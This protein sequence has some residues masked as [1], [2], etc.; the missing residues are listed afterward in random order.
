MNENRYGALEDTLRAAKLN[1]SAALDLR[2]ATLIES[3]SPLPAAR[4]LSFLLKAA[5][6]PLAAAAVL[7][8]M[9]IWRTSGSVPRSADWA[10]LAQ[11]LDNSRSGQWVHWVVDA[12]GYRGEA[13][14]AF[15]PYRY[16]LKDDG[17]ALY[18]D[19]GTGKQ[20]Y[21]ST[22]SGRVTVDP[23]DKNVYDYT[24]GLPDFFGELMLRVSR[25]EKEGAVL[26]RQ[27]TVFNGVACEL[28]TIDPTEGSIGFRVYVDRAAR[29][30]IREEAW[31]GANVTPSH[32]IKPTDYQYS[33]AGPED[34]YALGVPRDA[35]VFEGNLKQLRALQD[36]IES[37]RRAFAPSYFAV[38]CRA[39]VDAA[40]NVVPVE[41]DVVRKKDSRYRLEQYKVPD[42]ASVPSPDDLAAL[43]AWIA[44]A[45]V[46]RVWVSDPRP[47]REEVALWKWNAS[48]VEVDRFGKRHP[49]GGT[50]VW[51]ILTVEGIT[52]GWHL[53]VSYNDSGSRIATGH[54]L[55]GPLVTVEADDPPARFRGETVA[56]PTKRT[57]CFNPGRDHAAEAYQSDELRETGPAQHYNALEIRKVEEYAQTPAGR[58]YAK[59]VRT[60]RAGAAG[61]RSLELA[62]VHLDTSRAIHDE[63]MDPASLDSIGEDAPP[64]AE[65]GY[66]FKKAVAEIDAAP[67]YPA[68]PEDVAG[69][70]LA[71]RS[72]K[73]FARVELLMP[74]SAAFDPSWPA[75]LRDK[76][77]EEWVCG[78]ATPQQGTKVYRL[79]RFAGVSV[80]YEITVPCAR[81][82]HFDKDGIYDWY[83]GLSNASST[84]GRYYVV[85]LSPVN[86][87]AV[88]RKD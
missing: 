82:R 17:S 55:F 23:L 16:A 83:I 4:R 59:R 75:M 65:F 71:A 5:A 40:G 7:A 15:S 84:K 34:I 61:A 67:D 43:E 11:A 50:Y 66:Q 64:E 88:D 18:W 35:P 49:Y 26:T 14:L 1:T 69:A 53:P 80:P 27:Q 24:S 85:A 33:D 72:T 31:Y 52:W 21:Y 30:V 41:V 87:A 86:R 47:W 45:Q 77:P 54:G 63:L 20:Y 76:A 8:G 37:A 62:V 12:D 44:S 78:A 10:A 81:K 48:A 73:D 56:W 57:Y 68:T 79:P 3:S 6:V 9:F 32:D 29:R 22:D 74:G 39:S 13:W 58:W 70:F 38:I 36:S 19:A 25:F 46:W 51:E 2:I 28:F 42:G 60:E